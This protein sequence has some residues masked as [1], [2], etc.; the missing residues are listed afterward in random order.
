MIYAWLFSV[1]LLILGMAVYVTG[2][3]KKAPALLFV[4]MA[5]CMA[6]LVGAACFMPRG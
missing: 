4:G 1:A 3:E 5:F 2:I 6:G